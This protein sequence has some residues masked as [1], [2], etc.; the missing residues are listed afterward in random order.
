MTDTKHTR[1]IYNKFGGV[2]HEKR[3]NI[4]SSFWN[5]F[6]DLPAMTLLL[7]N[8]VKGKKTLDLGCGSGIFTAQ[9]LKWGADVSGIDISETMIN[10]ACKENYEIEFHVSNAL[11]TP[12][13][14]GCF[15][16]VSSGLMVHYF[17]DIN[18][19]FKE[20]KR[21][22]KDGGLFV[23]SFHHPFNEVLLRGE[24]R[25]IIAK[26]YFNNKKYKWKMKEGMELISYHHTFEVVFNALSKNG[27]LVERLLEPKPKSNYKNIDPVSYDF[28][29]KYPS[30]CAIKAIKFKKNILSIK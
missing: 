17:E 7:K 1:D 9:L 18:P 8:E 16:I 27:F 14:S 24:K 10:I 20:V 11:K 12:F 22:L 29:T 2:Y 3:K 21:L 4:K 5:R 23:F 26:P 13:K 6:I 28:T 19:L 15:D 30:F 25:N